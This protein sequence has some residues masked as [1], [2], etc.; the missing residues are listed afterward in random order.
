MWSMEYHQKNKLWII[1]VLE[2]EK[3]KGSENLF[4][5]IIAANSPNQGRDL[6]FQVCEAHRSPN[7]LN[8]KKSTRHI[9][10]KTVKN[11]RQREY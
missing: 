6:D 9:I 7:K 3:E 5:E 11:Q 1:G 10:I 4:K 8:L 2:K